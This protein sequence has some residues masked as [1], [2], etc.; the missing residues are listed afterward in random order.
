MRRKIKKDINNKIDVLVT[1]NGLDLH[2]GLKSS[3]KDFFDSKLRISSSTFNENEII[4]NIWY[5]ILT[6]SFM[7]K[8]NNGGRIV[9]FVENNNPLWMDVESLVE[10]VLMSS[11]GKG[12][13][14]VYDFIDR[15]LK[16]EIMMTHLIILK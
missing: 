8:I 15:I 11:N 12:I 4:S 3:F 5:L 9:P 16:I 7:L 1:G 14:L 13:I 2:C 10:K 6:F